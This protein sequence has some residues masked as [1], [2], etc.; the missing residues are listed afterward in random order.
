[1][2]NR[3]RTHQDAARILV[4]KVDEEGGAIDTRLS[5]RTDLLRL[6]DLG[7]SNEEIIRLFNSGDATPGGIFDHAQAATAL[8]GRAVNWT[9]EETKTGFVF[10]VTDEESA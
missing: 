5:H 10:I 2:G 4:E 9:G 7:I 3:Y 1:M 8:A 6:Q